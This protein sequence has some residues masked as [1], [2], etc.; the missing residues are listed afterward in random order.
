MDYSLKAFGEVMMRLEVPNH[1][2]LEQTQNLHVSYTGTGV[3]VLS[4]L[5]KYGHRTSLMTKLPNNSI[6][7]AAISYIQ[8]LGVGTEDIILGGDYIGMYFLENGFSVRPLR[9]TYSNRKE[10]SFCTSKITEYNLDS[11]LQN[12]KMIHFC[13]IALAISE[14]TRNLALQIAKRANELGVIVVFDCNFRPKL[15]EGNAC[16]AKTYYEAMLNVTNICF[17]TEK[18]AIYTLGMDTNETKKRHQIEQLIPKV[19]KKYQIETIAGTMRE[20]DK[21]GNQI[22][23]GFMYHEQSF[24]FSKPYTFQVLNRIGTGDGFA[25]GMIHSIT[26]KLHPDKA[27]EFATASG[28]L[29]HT[30]MGDAPVC[31]KEEV[32]ALVNDE[33]GAN[34]ER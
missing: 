17:L 11:M 14:N 28:V 9:V 3:N 19:A 13:G 8:S 1:L 15:W 10:S 6:G 34:I 27:V 12:T 20:T 7:Q 26:N 18:D 32:W 29:A 23:Q 33:N 4:A 5:S 16:E 31:T 2:K 21:D 22:L 24:A 25:S 30:T